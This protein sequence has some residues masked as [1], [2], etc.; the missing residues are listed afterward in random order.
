MREIPVDPI[1]NSRD[2][3][4]TIPAEPDPQNPNADPGI[5]NVK[6]GAEGTSLMGQAYTE[7]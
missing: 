4:Q 3:W 1:T 2:T 7:F 5:Y 6:S